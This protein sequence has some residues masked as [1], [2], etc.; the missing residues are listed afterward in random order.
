M[1]QLQKLDPKESVLRVPNHE[2]ADK[3]IRAQTIDKYG[4]FVCLLSLR[5]MRHV[6]SSS[7]HSSNN[8]LANV[9]RDIHIC[10]KN[11]IFI[12]C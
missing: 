9:Q 1:L 12:L 6:Q 3:I 4:R 10:D 8:V 2:K 7:T 5:K 11:D